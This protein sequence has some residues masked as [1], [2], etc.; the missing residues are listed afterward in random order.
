M[1]HR[2]QAPAR[3]PSPQALR[4]LSLVELM[5]SMVIGL[6][7]IGVVFANYLNSG[8]G[9]KSGTALSQ[10]SEDATVALNYLRKQITQAG[11]SGA[12]QLKADGTLDRAY[13][14]PGLFGCD[15]N[16]SNPKTG[17]ITELSCAGSGASDSIA[18]AY[19]ADAR[20]S[21]LRN[22][23]QPG[24]CVGTGIALTPAGTGPAY[25]LAES[26]L[27]IGA[28][29]Q[30]SLT[31]Q[32]N[33]LQAALPAAGNPTALGVAQPLVDN[34]VRLRIRYGLADSTVPSA[35]PGRPIRFV[36]AADV[37]AAA[38][39]GWRDVSAVRV[40]VVVRSE[41]E[42]LDAI[43]PYY[44]CDA[45]ESSETDPAKLLTTPPDRRMYRAFSTT[46]MIQNKLGA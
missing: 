44:G 25:Y 14:G 1:N 22:G 17:L 12:Y 2:T 4:G 7:V 10:M 27:Y 33:G 35:R 3:R 15:G 9:N 32:G 21:V 31:C 8:V 5:I 23:T 6:V 36:K 43:T 39:A 13:A 40:C 20:N 29:S 18:V 46:V 19:E 11:Y 37:G 38:A 30:S 45:I 42:V 24:D 41:N 34:I 28:G 16:F 26:R